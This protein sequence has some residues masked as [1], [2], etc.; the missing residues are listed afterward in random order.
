MEISAKLNQNIEN[1]FF[2]SITTMKTNKRKTVSLSPKMSFQKPSS[3]K[4]I[5]LG[6]QSKF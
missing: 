3:Y 1:L 6:V 2:Q 4:I 5:F